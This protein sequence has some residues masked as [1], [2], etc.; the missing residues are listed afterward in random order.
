MIT[1]PRGRCYEHNSLTAQAEWLEGGLS[2]A[3]DI[4]TVTTGVNCARASGASSSRP[5]RKEG[6]IP[7]G[8]C[9]PETDKWEAVRRREA[10]YGRRPSGKRLDAK[11]GVSVSGRGGMGKAGRRR[12]ENTVARRGMSLLGDPLRRGP[13]LYLASESEGGPPSKCFSLSPSTTLG[14]LP[15]DC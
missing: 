1:Y 5:L 7:S 4:G 2:P 11:R 10:L 15:W 8:T 3:A 13:L 9:W 12:G 14:T 6:R